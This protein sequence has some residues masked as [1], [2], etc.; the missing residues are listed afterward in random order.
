MT[1][2]YRI[3][4]INQSKMN[5]PTKLEKEWVLNKAYITEEEAWTDIQRWGLK[6]D[7]YTV[8]KVIFGEL[9]SDA[10]N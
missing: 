6:S 8:V 1:F 7:L 3:I 2:E 4:K 9:N 5:K 10:Y